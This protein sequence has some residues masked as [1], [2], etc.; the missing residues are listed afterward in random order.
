MKDPELSDVGLASSEETSNGT[1][2]CAIKPGNRSEGQVEEICLLLD[3]GGGGGGGGLD[4]MGEPSGA[5][6]L[7]VE[8]G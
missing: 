3:L 4:R 2:H 6:R 5:H 1:N 7:R 8:Q